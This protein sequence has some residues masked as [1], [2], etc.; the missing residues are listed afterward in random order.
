MEQV[1][2]NQA[3]GI[4]MVTSAGAKE[5]KTTVA[6]NLG[7][8]MAQAGKK[9]LL[10]DANLRAPLLHDFF[11]LEN[12]RGLADLLLKNDVPDVVRSAG[13]NGLWL[14]TGGSVPPNPSE[15]LGSE[16][17]Q[18]FLKRIRMLCDIVLLD[19]PPVFAAADAAVLAQLADGVLLVVKSGISTVDQ[20]TMAKHHLTMV[21]ANILGVVLNDVKM[22]N[23]KYLYWEQNNK[24]LS[25]AAI[26]QVAVAN[27]AGK[28]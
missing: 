22:G 21:G 27:D 15:L 11:A 10:V 26:A 25:N 16:A 9:V 7:V 12:S 2:K 23:S 17:M 8:V 19:T 3:A 6:A 4:V 14:V 20:V 1:L 24:K 18:I 13:I 5:G 28:G